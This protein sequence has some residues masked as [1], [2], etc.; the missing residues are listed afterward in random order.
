MQSASNGSLF[1]GNT[2]VKPCIQSHNSERQV[3]IESGLT[4][5]WNSQN[6]RVI[7]VIVA[8]LTPQITYHFCN[9]G[10]HTAFHDRSPS[11]HFWELST[12]MFPCIELWRLLLCKAATCPLRSVH[13]PVCIPADPYFECDH[14]VQSGQWA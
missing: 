10:V 3:C 7:S 1:G 6:F 2:Q 9:N 14:S 5:V 11:P 8:D 12:S 4:R 13:L